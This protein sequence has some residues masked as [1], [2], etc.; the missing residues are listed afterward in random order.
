MVTGVGTGLM[1]AISGCLQGVSGPEAA[2]VALCA[3]KVGKLWE[4]APLTFDHYIL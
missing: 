1:G 2:F 3:K 4:S